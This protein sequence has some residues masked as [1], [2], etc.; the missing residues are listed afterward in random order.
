MV[1]P[2]FPNRC[3]YCEKPR[4]VIIARTYDCPGGDLRDQLPKWHMGGVPEIHLC[5]TCAIAYE[6][7][8]DQINELFGGQIK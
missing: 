4:K 5:M 7:V 2:P 8:Q 1:T 6:N 3:A